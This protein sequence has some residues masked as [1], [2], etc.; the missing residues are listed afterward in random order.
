MNNNLTAPL[1]N[2]TANAPPV[3]SNS[4]IGFYIFLGFTF[5]FALL[6]L[7]AFGFAIKNLGEV[8]RVSSTLSE[9]QKKCSNDIQ[10]ANSDA[11]SAA[12][13]MKRGAQGPPGIQGP[14][15][16]TGGVHA[17]AGPLLC[18]GQKKVATPVT[19]TSPFSIIY[20]DDRR[21]TPIQ[22]WTL[23]NN[24]DRTVSVVNKFTGNCM[25]TGTNTK[26]V[27]SDRCANPVPLTQKFN[28]GPN[29]QLSSVA[30]QT[31]CL[32]VQNN[33]A[34]TNS[35]S[36]NKFDL[37]NMTEKQN[38]NNGSVSQLKLMECSQS[39]NLDQTWWVGN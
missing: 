10:Q 11:Q 21:Y 38:S 22:Y 39:Q 2:K 30:Q 37:N 29:M 19:G 1:L 23:R 7:I 27:Y 17:A 4:K 32:S 28:W 6:G 12:I 9:N 33:F 18:V 15:G 16:P 13:N 31:Q 34:M 5:V 26:D 35:N 25:T 24:P 8:S 36:N 20:L 14:P 3:Q